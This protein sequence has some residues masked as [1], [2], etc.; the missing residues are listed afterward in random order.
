LDFEG[1]PVYGYRGPTCESVISSY[2]G[3]SLQFPGLDQVN[4][5]L[6][7]DMLGTPGSLYPPLSPCGTYK[8]D[9]TMLLNVAVYGPYG[10]SSYE[11]APPVQVPILIEP[12][13]VPCAK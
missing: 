13:D 9:L 2:V 11:M 1:I 7:T 3:G 10:V 5:Q 4:F 6:P 12:G 8:M